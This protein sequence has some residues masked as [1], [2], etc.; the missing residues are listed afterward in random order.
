VAKI[1]YVLTRVG[2]YAADMA[3]NRDDPRTPR[4][5]V[6]DALRE[7]IKGGEYVP[8]SRLASVRELAKE[9]GVSSGTMQLALDA[10]RQEGL[11]FSAGNRGTFV[12]GAESPDVAEGTPGQVA[13][14]A[15]Q[16]ESLAE[17]VRVLAER[18]SAVEEDR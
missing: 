15:S 4:A 10:L 6:T 12:R 14:L 17:Q 13:E 7:G 11:I 5:Q 3:V 16:V 1:F 2:T 18:V 8:G 9:F